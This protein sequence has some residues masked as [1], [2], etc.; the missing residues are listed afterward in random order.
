MSLQR[1]DDLFNIH[2]GLVILRFQ[3]GN[4]VGGFFEKSL[5]AL[6]LFL[7]EVHALQLDNEIAEHVA[8]FPEILGAD[9][10]ERGVGEFRDVPL[11]IGAVVHHLLRVENVDLLGKFADSGLLGRGERRN[12]ELLGGSCRLLLFYG[13]GFLNGRFRGGIRGKGQLGNV[14]FTHDVQSFLS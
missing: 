5:E 3:R 10:V 2:L 9:A 13:R 12:V 11:R 6:L 1:F 14:G 4:A 7:T 8:D